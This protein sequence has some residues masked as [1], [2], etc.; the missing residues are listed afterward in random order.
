MTNRFPIIIDTLDGN[1]LK[2]LPAGDNLD[3]DGSGIVNAASI[4]TAGNL[5][6]MTLTV[7]GE[8]LSAVAFSNSFDDLD[9]VPVLF[10]GQYIDLTGKPFIP[11]KIEQLENVSNQTPNNGDTLIYD[12][13]LEN[14]VPQPVQIDLST[15]SIGDLGDVL[16]TGVFTNRYLKFTAG[17]WRASTIEWTDVRNKPTGVSVFINDAG[18]LT[19]D[20]IQDQPIKTDLIGSVFADDSTLLVDGVNGV[21]PGTLTGSWNN[22]GNI[23]NVIGE[24]I[25][26]STES[27]NFIVSN[28]GIS[29]GNTVDGENISLLVGNGGI[30]LSGSGN[31]AIAL[32]G[33]VTAATGAV[34]W[35]VN[36]TVTLAS[37]D[38]F[39]GVTGTVNLAASNI[40]IGPNGVTADLRGSVFAD[41]STLLVDGV[42]GDIPDYVKKQD[43]IDI[44]ADSADFDDF[45]TKIQDLL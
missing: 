39:W 26:V 3:L 43:L 9:D 41:D 44:V 7:N 14:Y 16:I 13:S 28:G 22:I 31:V 34:S 15:N 18:Y 42:N 45:K 36:G 19:V 32:G 21:V 20:S 4:Q 1:K 8:P 5:S 2:E 11:T 25:S 35:A 24:G 30:T 10:S 27:T 17:A 33:A 6:A 29:F 12:A 38:L 23:F 40:N 37:E